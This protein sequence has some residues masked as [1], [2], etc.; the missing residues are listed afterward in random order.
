MNQEISLKNIE[1]GQKKWRLF[2][3][4]LIG[5][6]Q[7]PIF[8]L[9]FSWMKWHERV[10][11]S[12]GAWKVKL[13]FIFSKDIYRWIQLSQ[14]SLHIVV[15][16]SFSQMAESRELPG[17]SLRRT[18]IPFLRAPHSW[19]NRD[20]RPHLLISSHWDYDFD[21]WIWGNTKTFHS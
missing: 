18:L 4:L 7:L 1:D 9:H 6:L 8:L 13:L 19:P 21:I 3:K 15:F 5:N 14:G 11:E 20:S 16:L 2:G 10:G 17:F 12:R